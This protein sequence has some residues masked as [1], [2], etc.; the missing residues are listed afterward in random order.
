MKKKIKR[1]YLIFDSIPLEFGG[2]KHLII[3]L[4]G[5]NYT[6]HKLLLGVYSHIV[7][8]VVGYFASLFF[9]S[10]GNISHLT[11][12]GWKEQRKNVNFT[13]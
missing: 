2:H 8:F 6:H 12:H 7:L 9:K 4:G 11:F 13:V 3:N 1:I 10:P 5:F